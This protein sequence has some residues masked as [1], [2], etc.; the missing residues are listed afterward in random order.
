MDKNSQQLQTLQKIGDKYWKILPAILIV[1][2]LILLVT[3]SDSEGI[4]NFA[5]FLV[6]AT[7]MP[8][9]IG[10]LLIVME[11]KGWLKI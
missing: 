2:I 8:L 5:W 4:R 3:D 1:G 11:K 7:G 9:V 10:S 6:Y